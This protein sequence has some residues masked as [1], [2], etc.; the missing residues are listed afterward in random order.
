M[1]RDVRVQVVAG[2]SLAA[3]LVGMLVYLLPERTRHLKTP[4]AATVVT[5]EAT[6]QATYVG[7]VHE[8]FQQAAAMLHA[9]QYLYALEALERVL[10]LSPHLPEAHVNVGFALLGLQHP[11]RA[12]EHFIRATDLRAGQVNAYYGLAV[13]LEELGDIKGALG[14][15]RT[16]VHLSRN[17]D[18]HVLR[19][20]AAIW[21]WTQQPEASSVMVSTPE[22]DRADDVHVGKGS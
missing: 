1:K 16:F 22:S 5:A 12:A 13:A 17:D 15:M 18:P 11:E 14:A 21:E 9:G 7:E 6:T 2:V 8:R 20:K 19:A 10:E 3:L 4:A